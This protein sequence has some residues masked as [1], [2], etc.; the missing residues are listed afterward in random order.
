MRQQ[1]RHDSQRIHFRARRGAETSEIATLTVNVTPPPA[2]PKLN[3]I[4][5]PELDRHGRVRLRATCDRAC[6]VSLRV[7]IRL[8]SQRVLRG[9]VVK[10]SAPAGKTLR[11]KLQRARLP[12]H[13]RIVAA[14]IAGTLTGP[15]GLHRNFTLTLIP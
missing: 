8:N 14:R 10:A 5:Q 9:R 1:H 11:L 13:R 15:D 2:A 3:V 7:I 12:R 4:G 6:S